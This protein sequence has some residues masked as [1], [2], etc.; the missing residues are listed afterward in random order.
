MEMLAVFL[1][2]IWPQDQPLA[3]VAGTASLTQHLLRYNSIFQPEGHQ[4]LH[5]KV[6]T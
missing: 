5:N 2:A 4:E 3:T 1:T 6:R